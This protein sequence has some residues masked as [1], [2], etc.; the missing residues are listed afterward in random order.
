MYAHTSHSYVYLLSQATLSNQLYEEYVVG[1][2][3]L[4]HFLPH[5]TP[6]AD[7]ICLNFVERLADHSERVVVFRG[8]TRRRRHF[9]AV[10]PLGCHS[11]MS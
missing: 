7:R 2:F 3:Y 10:F 1:S 11:V 8:P 4:G 6:F 9:R 5:S